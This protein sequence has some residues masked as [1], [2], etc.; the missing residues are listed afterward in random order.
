[1]LILTPQCP[2]EQLACDIMRRILSDNLLGVEVNDKE[3]DGDSDVLERSVDILWSS[4]A[5]EQISAVI[6]DFMCEDCGD[7][8]V[9]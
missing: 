2:S 5:F 4:T 8:E 9:K 6:M 1:M 3:V 7:M